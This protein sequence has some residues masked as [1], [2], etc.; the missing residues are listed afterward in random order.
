MLTVSGPLPFS[1]RTI[2]LLARDYRY[3]CRGEF[4]RPYLL[5][6]F[7]SYR[8]KKRDSH[9]ST[10]KL[11]QR[12]DNEVSVDPESDNDGPSKSASDTPLPDADTHQHQH[13]YFPHLTQQPTNRS[14]RSNAS[15]IM[16]HE[17]SV[18]GAAPYSLAGRAAPRT[19]L[20]VPEEPTRP[21]SPT[22]SPAHSLAR[23]VSRLDIHRFGRT[24]VQEGVEF[25]RALATP[26]TI[27]LGLALIVALVKPLKALFV[28]VADYHIRLAPDGSE[29]A[30][31]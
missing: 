26:P 7:S 24:F 27:S 18:A 3:P 1:M 5:E 16:L 14:Q 11:K 2:D 8:A 31:F 15:S 4:T 10:S 17:M 6:L 9:D 29:F 20:E 13:P 25:L 21:N 22:F 28:P 23:S 12:D 30:K 19:V